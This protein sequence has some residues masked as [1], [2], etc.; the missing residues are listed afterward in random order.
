MLGFVTISGIAGLVS[1][2]VSARL[3]TARGH[4]EDTLILEGDPVEVWTEE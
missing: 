3:E 4:Y 2:L 1:K